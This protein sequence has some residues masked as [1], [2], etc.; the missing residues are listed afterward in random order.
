MD[1]IELLASL[2]KDSNVLL[3]VG[4]DHALTIIKAIKYYNVKKAIAS[5]ISIGPLMAA[6][7]NIEN[8]NLIDK[9]TIIQSD[10]LKNINEEFDTLIISGM[11]G[12]LIKDI[13]NDSLN[14]IKNKLLILEANNNRYILRKFLSE[15]NFK[16]IDEYAIYDNL[17]YYE[18]IVAKTGNSSLT[19]KELKYGPILMKKKSK[20]F[21]KFYQDK[22]NFIDSIINTIN[23]ENKKKLK[24]EEKEEYLSLL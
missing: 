24:L 22:I 11:G 18:I 1:R 10:G 4:C 15:N 21:I 2:A 19:E 8:N 12:Y 17:K 7:K 9:I 16:I 5:D 23:D 13:L 20:E 14:K 6:K 3:D